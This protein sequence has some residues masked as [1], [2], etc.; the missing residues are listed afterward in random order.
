MVSKYVAVNTPRNTVAPLRE[1]VSLAPPRWMSYPSAHA[2]ERNKE[3][4]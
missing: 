4:I 1:I 2:G 3:V